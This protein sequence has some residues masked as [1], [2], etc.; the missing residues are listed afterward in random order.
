MKSKIFLL[1]SLL[2]AGTTVA[3]DS[4]AT[5]KPGKDNKPVKDAF[6]SNWLMNNQSMIVPFAKTL[7]FD[8][9]HRFGTIENGFDDMLGMYAPSNIRL[10][11]TFTPIKNLQVG[12]GI[13]KAAMM[14]DLN[15][16]WSILQQTRSGSIPVFVTYYGNMVIEGTKNQINWTIKDIS[17]KDSIV[18]RK[19]NKDASRFSYF[20]QLIIGRKFNDWLSLQVG[21]SFSHFNLINNDT[22]NGGI[23]D[24]KHDNL[25]VSLAGRVKTTATMSVLFAYDHP[26]TPAKDIKPN[27]ALGVEWSTGS[28][29]FQIFLS[30]YQSI[31]NQRDV[32][33]NK[34]DFTKKEVAISFNITRLWNF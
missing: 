18:D 22:T 21:A 6:E 11:V 33:Y 17:G 10:G 29:A 26:L 24:L 14:N 32:A 9:N 20:N 27:L 31:M 16:K 19:F 4:T 28:H 5:E 1:L 3:Q 25:A 30:P 34:N 7:E 13:T 23:Q 2:W 8:I 15:L 12:G